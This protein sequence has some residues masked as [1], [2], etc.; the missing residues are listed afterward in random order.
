MIILIYIYFLKFTLGDYAM[1]ISM[2]A[3]LIVVIL[4][5]VCGYGLG[6]TMYEPKI[7]SFESQVSSL[8]S[9]VSMFNST[10]LSQQTQTSTM[11]GLPPF[12]NPDFDV[13]LSSPV[14]IVPD[15]GGSVN[16][17]VTLKATKLNTSEVLILEANSTIPGYVA[18]FKPA[19]VTLQPRD[20]TSVELT[21]TVPSG[22]PKDTY[23]MSIVAKGETTQGGSW[24]LIA[25]GS[26]LKVPPP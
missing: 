9:E 11:E 25:V 23:P 13:S 6:Y 14:V 21:V 26:S 20:T 16:V 8:T 18:D 15:S 4:V 1:K 12:V 10:V 5:G 3:L 2:V 22:V 19:S 17:S 7:R 24:L